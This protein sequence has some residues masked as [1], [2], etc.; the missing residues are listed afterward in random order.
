MKKMIVRL[1]LLLGLMTLLTVTALAA[2]PVE[3]S[4]ETDGKTYTATV[5]VAQEAS[6]TSGKLTVS[7]DTAQLTLISAEPAEALEK[8]VCRIDTSKPGVVTFVFIQTQPVSGEALLNLS[9][10]STGEGSVSDV[11]LTVSAEELYLQLTPV[12]CET[13]TI[14]AKKIA[15]D[16]GDSCPSKQYTDVLYGVWYHDSVDYMI[17]NEY[18]NGMSASVFAPEG[19]TTRAQLVQILYRIEGNPDVTGA[20]NP[21][22]DVLNDNWYTD[23]IVWAASNGI[24]KGVTETAFAPDDPITREQIAVILYRYTGATAPETNG[25]S[26]FPDE[27]NTSDWAKDAL[28]WAIANELIN[29]VGHSDGGS[30]LEPLSNATRAQIATILTRYLER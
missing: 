18:M 21:F 17:Q 13:L 6:V 3:G 26:A 29:G 19:V 10:T 1:A 16:G 14:Y 20:K 8:A 24:V 2:D 12:E 11:T 22:T 7:Y 5:S 23:A 28:N 30:Y 27:K 4:M 9:F 15:C 25:L